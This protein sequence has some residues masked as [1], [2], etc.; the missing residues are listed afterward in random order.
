MN[1]R[2]LADM[3]RLIAE[4]LHRIDR[5]KFDCIV[6]IP[7]SGMIPAAMLATH[8]QLP[9]ADVRGY[10]A[11]IVNGRSG[12]SERPGKRVLLVD[13][14]ANKGAAMARALALLPRGTEVTRLAI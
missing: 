2:S 3:T 5:T 10:A 4:N 7:R 1:I 9:L 11:G 8:L 13:D 12:A 6:G 14:S